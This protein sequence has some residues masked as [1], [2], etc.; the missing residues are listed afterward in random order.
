MARLK[1]DWAIQRWS[2][3]S[4]VIGADT[5]GELDGELLLKPVDADNARAMLMRMSGRD[6]WVHTAVTILLS[7]RNQQKLVSTK[8]RFRSLRPAEVLAYCQMGEGMDKAGAYAI[9][10]AGAALVESIEGSYSAVVGLPLS[11]VADALQTL[12]Y[13]CWQESSA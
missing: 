13:T 2:P 11:E 10:G 5:I 4:V 12:G 6:H 3:P 8:V 1:A 7:G 9:Q